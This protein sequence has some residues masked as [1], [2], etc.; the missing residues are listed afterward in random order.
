MRVHSPLPR[1]LS[2]VPWW[3]TP[4]SLSIPLS[5]HCSSWRSTDNKDQGKAQHRAH[6]YLYPDFWQ[7]YRRV[8]RG[9]VSAI[10]WGAAGKPPFVCRLVIDGMA[11]SLCFAVVL[12]MK[13]GFS[14]LSIV[15]P[16]WKSTYNAGGELL[17]VP[18]G[19]CDGSLGWKNCLRIFL[20]H[21]FGLCFM[22]TMFKEWSARVW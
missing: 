5:I 12:H 16:V 2:S 14:T 1:N 4:G 9:W 8:E 22:P 17:S 3:A 13:L 15:W 18:T 21:G 10:R 6:W 7:W 20:D 19:L 11:T